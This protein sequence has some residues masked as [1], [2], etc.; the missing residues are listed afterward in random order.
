[1]SKQFCVHGHDTFVVGRRP[2]PH[3]GC[4]GCAH[5][6]GKK[7]REKN[8]E[9]AKEWNYNRYH[10][11]PWYLMKATWYKREWRARQRAKG[12]RVT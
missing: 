11:D 6:H 9:Y 2:K 4:R 5:E 12:G 8:P 3:G 7:W 1:M 10:T